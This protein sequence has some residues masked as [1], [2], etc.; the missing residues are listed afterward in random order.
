MQSQNGIGMLV[1][2]ANNS[3]RQYLNG[4]A[5]EGAYAAHYDGSV[6]WYAFNEL[7]FWSFGSYRHF[8]IPQPQ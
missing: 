6:R 3:S 2:Q 1:T 8:Y 7:S 4:I 5:P